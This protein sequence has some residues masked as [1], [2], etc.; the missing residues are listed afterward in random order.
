MIAHLFG[1]RRRQARRQQ[2][3]RARA[4]AASP[5]PPTDWS[6][7]TRAACAAAS[8]WAPAWSARPACCCSTSP[9]PASTPAAASSCGTPSGPWCEGG[10]D[11]LLTTQYLDEADQLAS[12][13]VIVD[14]GRV[15]VSGTPDELK[16]P[17]RPR[18]DRDPPADRRRPGPGGRRPWPRSAPSRPGSIRP[19]AAWP[20]PSTAG[21]SRLPDAVRVLDQLGVVADDIAQRRPTLDEVF[22]TLTGEHIDRTEARM[23]ATHHPPRRTAT[24]AAR[25]EPA[26]PP[27]RRVLAAARPARLGA[28]A[29][30]VAGRTVRKFVRTPQL[31]VVST[32]QGAM[33][34]LIFRYVFGGAIDAGPV[35]LRRLPGARASWSPACCSRAWAVPPAWPRTCTTASST[36]SGRCRCAAAGWSPAERWPTPRC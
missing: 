16:A 27:A 2:P 33:F 35:L 7:P 11:V 25:P 36:G 23:T 1:H 6:A 3:G 20:S 10:T 34:L 28:T 14:H 31:L 4:A 8:T 9:P 26:D 30:S 21:A 24:G 18:R 13:I 15:V 32:I 17:G 22:L 5:T 19:P 29:T 12:D